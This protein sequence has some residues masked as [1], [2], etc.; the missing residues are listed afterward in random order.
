ME[1]N[2]PNIFSIGNVLFGPSYVSVESALV[3]HG[4]IPEQ[5]FSIVSVKIK[6]SKNFTNELGIFAYK[7]LPTP[8]YSFSI[9]IKIEVEKQP[10]L[11][12]ETE[13]KL[14]LQPYSFYVKCFQIQ[15]LFAG[16]IHALLF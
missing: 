11:G 6:T 3:F 9:K 13:E 2:S 5:V 12:F 8:Y 1:R 10:L 16:K 15:D 14:L 7:H 4:L